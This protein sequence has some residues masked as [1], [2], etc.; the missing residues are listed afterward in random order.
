MIACADNSPEVVSLLLEHKA[1]P[2]HVLTGRKTCLMLASQNS[3]MEVLTILLKSKFIQLPR[4]I[5]KQS[6]GGWTA[7]ALAYAHPAAVE[8][9]LNYGADPNLATTD[10]WTPLMLACQGDGCPDTVRL[11]LK[12]NAE[13]NL[14]TKLGISAFGLAKWNKNKEIMEILEKAG[15]KRTSIFQNAVTKMFASPPSLTKKRAAQQKG[16]KQK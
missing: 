13:P 4:I 16:E 6:D 9:L 5:D 11:L 8:L 2:Y 12:Y 10:K 15:A 3:H 14:Q 7:L 1:D